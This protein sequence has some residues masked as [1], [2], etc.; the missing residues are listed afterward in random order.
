MK[1]KAISKELKGNIKFNELLKPYTSF[2]IG[3]TTPLFIEEFSSDSLMSDIQFLNHNGIPYKILGNATN[4]LINDTTLNYAIVKIS[5]SDIVF[6]DNTVIV[7]AGVKGN[8]LIQ[9]AKALSLGGMEFMVGIPGTIGGMIK[10]NAGAYD[11]E[12]GDIV[13]SVMFSDGKWYDKPSFSYRS[14]N[15]NDI[16]IKAK[17]SLSFKDIFSINNKIKKI[18]DERKS[19]QPTLPSAGSVFKKPSKDFYVGKVIDELGLKGYKIG[20]AMISKIH[21]GFIVNVGNATFTDVIKL[22]EFVRNEVYKVY[23]QELELEINIWR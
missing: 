14:S 18:L 6:E 3:G 9:K 10:I 8:F 23:K 21:A 5:T 1:W 22:I 16:V 4:L 13:S 7:D 19:K 12:M 2:K 15:I 11:G 17:L 20:G